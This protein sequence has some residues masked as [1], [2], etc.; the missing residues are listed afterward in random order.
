MAVW[1]NALPTLGRN[2]V[3]QTIAGSAEGRT[4]EIDALYNALL[5]RP[6]DA[7]GLAGWLSS[8]LDSTQLRVGFESTTE[9]FNV[10]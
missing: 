2:G 4:H 6:A 10:G 9:F 3:A 5:H 1:V 7:T 8:G